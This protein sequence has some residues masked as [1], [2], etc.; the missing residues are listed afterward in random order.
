MK[1][2]KQLIVL[3]LL[4]AAVGFLT[5]RFKKEYSIKNNELSNRNWYAVINCDKQ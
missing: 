1:S 5:L 3:F 4:I 2:A